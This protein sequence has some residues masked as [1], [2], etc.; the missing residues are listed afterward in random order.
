MRAPSATGE[1]RGHLRRVLSGQAA[2]PREVLETCVPE[3]QG[4]SLL[5]CTCLSRTRP[6]QG[7]L[8]RAS[9]DTVPVGGDARDRCVSQRTFF[10]FTPVGARLLGFTGK[11]AS[12]KSQERS[13]YWRP[14]PACRG[15]SGSCGHSGGCG[16]TRWPPASLPPASA[17]PSPRPP[18]RAPDT[19][20]QR[21][22][23]LCI[24][25]LLPAHV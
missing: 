16:A 1:A 9:Q 21:N 5:S 11:T 23:S 2:S 14:A 8:G 20:S 18:L 10:L 24:Y 12:V 13:H 25:L 6:T 7:T 3:R 4:A 22:A 19:A 15:D 17:P